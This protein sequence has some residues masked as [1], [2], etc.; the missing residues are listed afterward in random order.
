L[1]LNILGKEIKNKVKLKMLKCKFSFIASTSRNL[2]T[3]SILR[4]EMPKRFDQE[5]PSFKPL[6]EYRTKKIED[7][8]KKLVWRQSFQSMPGFYKSK[9]SVFNSEE[10]E[11]S[12]LEMVAQPIDIS[13]KGVKRWW[14]NYKVR[15]EKYLQQYIPQR[16]EILG[17]DL[18]AAHFLLFRQVKYVMHLKIN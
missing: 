11:P 5:V 1:R 8:K 10:M 3:T 13:A 9:L 6:S 17:N 12:T 2:V 16:H 4:D 15:K 14:S 18:A 7:D